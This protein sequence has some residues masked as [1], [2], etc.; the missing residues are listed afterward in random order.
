MTR[1][2]G[3]G[4]AVGFALVAA[5][6]LLAAQVLLA[7]LLG[8]RATLRGFAVASAVVYLAGLG[9]SWRRG[10]A[11][12]IAAGA[13][14]LVLL[15]LPIP[16]AQTA[17]AAAGLVAVGRSAILYRSR[18]LRALVLEVALTAGGL[19]LASRLVGGGIASLALAAWG[20]FLVQSLF[21]LV[22]G[23][24]ARPD[25]GPA[26]PFERARAQLLALLD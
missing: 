2:N 11:A 13:A 15:A 10:A 12:A 22:G 9:P 7:P 4:R 6:A 5:G 21:F 18:P 20:Y 8:A 17:A 14:G 26:D 24:E 3:F 23:I 1:W 16:V 25:P 19:V